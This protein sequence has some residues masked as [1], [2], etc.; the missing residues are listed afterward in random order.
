MSISKKR[1]LLLAQL[2]MIRIYLRTK[3]LLLE[4]KGLTDKS[5]ES[6]RPCLPC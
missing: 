4:N 6:C 3:Q 1:E 2:I 5:K